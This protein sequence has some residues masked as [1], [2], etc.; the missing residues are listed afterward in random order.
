MPRFWRGVR[1]QRN[2]EVNVQFRD[3]QPVGVR[4]L[5]PAPAGEVS[6]YL[7]RSLAR[8]APSD[9]LSVLDLACGTGRHAIWLATQGHRVAALDRDD[10]R[11]TRLQHTSKESRASVDAIVGDGAQPLPFREN[12]FDLVLV[13]HF[14]PP[15]LIQ[16]VTPV[17]RTGGHLIVETFGG[18]G[19]NWRDLPPASHFREALRGAFDLVD[20]RERAVGPTKNVGVA[21]KLLARKR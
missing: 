4:L 2:I 17:I 12:S 1:P 16:A 5:R 13:V 11:V 10:A 14:V 20:Y 7:V 6:A 3:S 19:G 15:S 9:S 18:Q 8:I 21:V